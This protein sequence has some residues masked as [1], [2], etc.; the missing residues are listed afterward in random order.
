MKKIIYFLGAFTLL[1]NSC[2]HDIEPNMQPSDSST[3]PT[4]PT[5]PSNP[6]PSSILLKKTITN[7]TGT[8][9]T[10]NLT[11]NGNKIVSI[12]D[13]SAEVDL[14]FTYT[15][16]NITKLEYKLNDGTIDQV[17]NY[18]YDASGR[19]ISMV[20]LQPNSNW[21]NKETYTYNTDGTV[22]V[23][24]YSGDLI[25]QTNLDQ[26][27][28]IYF[29][30]GEVS[31]IELFDD[32]GNSEDVIVYGYDNKINPLKNIT[33]YSKLNFC[34]SIANGINNNIISENSTANGPTSYTFVYESNNYPKMVTET[35]GGTSSTTQFFY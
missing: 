24:Y 18:S 2:S 32:L 13:D 23:S 17:D 8:P 4:N 1:L 25:S 15:G 3:N 11:Y 28:K 20:Y 19:I 14:F 31:K 29:T 6:S 33:G 22:S 10:S 12:I 16:D 5:N 26:T 34:Y 30:N 9:I 7:E 27:G 35:H 21:G